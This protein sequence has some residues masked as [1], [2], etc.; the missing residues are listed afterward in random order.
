MKTFLAFIGLLLAVSG[1]SQ[2]PTPI[3]NL[4]ST[5][6]FFASNWLAIVSA[7]GQTN[8][9]K[10]ISGT[11]LAT[12][13][14]GLIGSAT[15]TNAVGH[16]KTNGVSVGTGLNILDLIEGTNVVFR[17][18]NSG[19]TALIQINSSGSGSGATTNANQFGATENGQIAI[20]LG[21]LTTNGVTRGDTNLGAWFTDHVQPT[22]NVSYDLGV[23]GSNAW[24]NVFSLG[25]QFTNLY[26]YNDLYLPYL[27][28]DRLLAVNPNGD[29]TN[30]QSL[31]GVTYSGGSLSA[32]GASAGTNSLGDVA[33]IGVTN[34]Q[35]A[36][37]GS[38]VIAHLSNNP[39]GFVTVRLATTGQLN[40]WSLFPTNTMNSNALNGVLNFSSNQVKVAAGAN[41]TV[42]PS[43]SG[44]VM[45][46]TVAS[47]GGSASTNNAVEAVGTL[48]LTNGV[49]RVRTNI[50]DGAFRLILLGGPSEIFCWSPTNST[51]IF[52][53][54]PAAGAYPN[55][56]S[57]SYNVTILPGATNNTFIADTSYPIDWR[58]GA[59]AATFWTGQTNEYWFKFTGSNF[60]GY[61]LT[62][63][64][65]GTGATVLSNAPTVGGTW[66]FLGSAKITNGI[67]DS[68]TIYT[69]ATLDYAGNTKVA[70]I[71]GSQHLLAGTLSSLASGTGH[72]VG[73]NAPTINNLSTIGTNF[74]N[75]I[76]LPNIASNSVVYVGGTS[77]LQGATMGWGVDLL[78]GRLSLTNRPASI[79]TN[80]TSATV[81]FGDTANIQEYNVWWQLTTNLVISP[82]NLVV[83]RT[84][85]IYFNT[86]SLTYDVQVT[87]TAA[88]EV[89]WNFNV[90]T[91]GS[92]AF[93]KTNT[94]RARLFLT[95]ETNSVITADFGY[96]R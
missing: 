91:N 22:A 51:Y 14:S 76:S 71:D 25:G 54:V 9:T 36:S 6:N 68:P 1:F 46:Y 94:L 13:L 92:T 89:H 21:A 79:P 61:H 75:A 19:Q 10:R 72:Q 5:T 27:T 66:N 62:E 63:L 73:T 20:K 42:T 2:N 58:T 87:N 29:L 16:I 26:I 37:Y 28:A 48:R 45:T 88:T 34:L 60:L 52:T 56:F 69:A 43:G 64:F 8:G 82:T 95:C 30:V 77:N 50:T 47:T 17:A 31:V 57:E 41:V 81:D 65:T 15:P 67:F 38:N 18:T 96:Y 39:S 33:T 44:N 78:A 7:P 84:Q 49:E 32:N 85:K 93:T 40:N 3:Y 80:A 55:S 53:N 83:G 35:F 59:G 12:A 86:N 24:R 90:A 74:A 4:P 11:N 70:I 23:F